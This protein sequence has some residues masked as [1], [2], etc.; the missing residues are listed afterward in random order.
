M[1]VTACHSFAEYCC[2]AEIVSEAVW[3]LLRF[4]LRLRVVEEMLTSR[5]IVVSYETLR[6]WGRKFGQTFA[7]ATRRHQVMASDY[8]AARKRALEVWSD[9]SGAA[10]QT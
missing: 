2:Q 9:I 8:R 1:A 5:R 4:L 6:H 7:N 10:A 3:L